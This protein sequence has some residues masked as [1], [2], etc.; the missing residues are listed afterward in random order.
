MTSDWAPDTRV[1]ALGRPDRRADEPLNTPIVPASSFHAGGPLEYAREGNPTVSSLEDVLGGLE[2][3]IAVAFASGMAA[4]NAMLDAVPAGG[5]VVAP[6]RTYT[7][8]AVRL[9][10]LNAV[11]RIN[12]RLVEAGDSPAFAAACSGADMVWIE[13]P[14]N[15]TLEVTDIRL[16][17][18]A[19]RGA[20]AT[21]VVDNTFATPLRQQ[22]LSLGADVVVHSVTKFL[23]GHSD[24]LM[25]ALVARDET[26]AEFLRTRRVLLGAAPGVLEAYLATRGARTLA[27]R[28]DRA[29]ASA[30]RLASLL[31]DHPAVQRVHY[32]G[33]PTDPGHAVMAAQTS[34]FGS[35]L[36]IVLHGGADAADRVSE[37][38][39]LWTHATSLG[40]VESLIERRR[41]WPAESVSVP[42][43]L[44]R[45]SVG[46]ENVDDLWADLA[47]ALSHA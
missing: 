19:A 5:V 6:T 18:E 45:L 44:L 22:P 43:G 36:S 17:A 30:M 15:P 29:E 33:L 1:V 42:E 13:S 47:Q 21:V 40:G 24:L 20:G 38:V 37:A 8:T 41:R 27:L 2:G 11:G 46:I 34:G 31:S 4:V 35:M 9:R 10:E 39:T 25:G 14:T 26:L 12:L 23:G 32:P 7:G 16:V 3:G 28:L